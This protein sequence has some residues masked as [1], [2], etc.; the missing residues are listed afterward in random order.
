[1]KNKFKASKRTRDN[2]A[3]IDPLTALIIYEGQ[4]LA[5]ERYGIDTTVYEGVREDD[6]QAHLFATGKSRVRRSKHQRAANGWG[7]AADVLAVG[8]IDSNGRIDHHDRALMWD[9]DTYSK[10]AECV[11]ERADDYNKRHAD[12]GLSIVM[13][14][15]GD[16]DGDGIRVDRDPDESFLD[17]FH[18]ERVW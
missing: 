1:M 14:W 5:Y 16:W 10:I 17:V 3:G 15:G 12:S 4:Q 6:R 18:F 2:L 13:R 11:F 7:Y 8:D 9:P